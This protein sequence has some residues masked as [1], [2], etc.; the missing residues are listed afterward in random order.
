MPQPSLDT[1]LAKVN[2]YRGRLRPPLDKAG[3]EALIARKHPQ[4]IEWM[5]ILKTVV[6]FRADGPQ[7]C[8]R[9]QKKSAA[10]DDANTLETVASR[11]KVKWSKNH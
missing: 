1:F 4:Q 2:Q 8:R 7:A 6:K 11:D 3:L 9:E 5:S 10:F